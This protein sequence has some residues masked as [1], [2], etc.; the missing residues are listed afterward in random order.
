MI[1]TVI[2]PKKTK[3]PFVSPSRNTLYEMLCI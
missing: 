3:L 2:A 1:P